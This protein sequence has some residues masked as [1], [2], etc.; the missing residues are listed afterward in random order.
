MQILSA[1]VLSLV[2]EDIHRYVI[3]VALFLQLMILIR[4]IS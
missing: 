1:M 2:P 3:I 4:D